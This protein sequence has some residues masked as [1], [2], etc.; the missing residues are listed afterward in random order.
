MD[1][2]DIIYVK[3]GPKIVGKGVVDGP[4]Q[5]DK[6]NRIV[7]PDGTPWQHQ[8]RVKWV[9]GFPEIPIQ[10]GRQQAMTLVPLAGDDVKQ[11]EQAAAAC[12]AEESDIEGTKTEIIQFKTKRSRKLRDL[13]LN[14]AHGICCAC[15]RDYSKLLGGRGVK[16]L[17]VHHRKQ[18]AAREMPSI[19]KLGDL[20]VVCATATC[21]CILIRRTP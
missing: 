19:T 17:Q 11:V 15:G 20:V 21:F 6:K 4:Y 9:A 5:F 1:E 18:L 14:A 10:I 2:G 8:R 13:A 16:V 7:D 12:F 3:Q